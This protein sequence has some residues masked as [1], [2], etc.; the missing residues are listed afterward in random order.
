VLTKAQQTAIQ[1]VRDK[2]QAFQQWKHKQEMRA[3]AEGKDY[4][5]DEGFDEESR[6]RG[7]DKG[8]EDDVD[9]GFEDRVSDEEVKQMGQIQQ[10]VLRFCITLL[11]HLL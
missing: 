9:E 6:R 11:D 3:E 5:D 4:G 2:I 1:T 10:D 8:A 7:D